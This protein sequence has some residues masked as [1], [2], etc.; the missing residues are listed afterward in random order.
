MSGSTYVPPGDEKPLPTISEYGVPFWEGAHHHEVRVQACNDCGRHQFPPRIL[1]IHCGSRRI[2]W[3]RVSGS[4]RVYS[5]TVIH[6]APEPAFLKDV[7]Y[8]VAVV[9]LDEGGRIMTN[10]IGCRPDDV[11]CDMR[12]EPVFEDVN[13]TVTLIK[14]RPA[15]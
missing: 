12:V 5:F 7:P 15:P 3:R 10:V 8:V 6:R 4:G 2:E 14:F 11:R 13:D 9:E 1:C